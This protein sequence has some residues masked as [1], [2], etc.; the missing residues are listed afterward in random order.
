MK[1][2]YFIISNRI[3]KVYLIRIPSYVCIYIH[4]VRGGQATKIERNFRLNLKF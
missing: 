4:G 1:S 2:V 3:R